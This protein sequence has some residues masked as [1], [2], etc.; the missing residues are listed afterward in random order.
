MFEPGLLLYDR[1]EGPVSSYRYGPAIVSVG[2]DSERIYVS[3]D[4]PL[5]NEITDGLLAWFGMDMSRKVARYR[6]D[7][8]SRYFV[9]TAA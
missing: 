2:H 5:P 4:R 3:V 8:N 1:T 9:Q 6:F 7:D